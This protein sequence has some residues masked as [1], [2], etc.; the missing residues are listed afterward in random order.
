MLQQYGDWYTGRWWAGC[1][2]WYSE[3]GPGLAEVP[4]SP[5][6]A[7]L[8]LTAHPSTASVP[9]SYYSMRHY[10]CLWILNGWLLSRCN[11]VDGGSAGMPGRREAALWLADP[12]TSRH[13]ST[14][15]QRVQRGLATDVWRQPLDWS[16]RQLLATRYPTNNIISDK[17]NITSYNRNS[18]P[19]WSTPPVEQTSSA[20]R[21]DMFAPRT[22]TKLG[23]RSFCVMLLQ[24]SGTLFLF[25]GVRRPSVEDTS[26]LGWKPISS[27]KPTPASENVYFKSELTYLL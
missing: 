8:N 12:W 24:L 7:V 11:D 15:L 23:R 6:F 13:C 16:N 14:R 19:Q 4:P 20:H 9:T 25:I 18:A 2:I 21:G 22:R 26:E 5:L 17:F 27:I 1:Y 3:E 10:Y